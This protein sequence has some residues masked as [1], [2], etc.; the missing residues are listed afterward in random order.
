MAENSQPLSAANNMKM[1]AF[2]QH[3]IRGAQVFFKTPLS[4][5]F[6]NKKPV[7][8]GHVLVSPLRVVERFHDMTSEEVADMFRAVHIIAKAVE[9]EYEGTAMSL[10]LQDGPDAGQT[11][12]HVHIHILPRR[13]GDFS[14]NDE[15]YSHLQDHD[16]V[17]FDAIDA[18]REWRSEEDMAQEATKL[19]KLFPQSYT[20]DL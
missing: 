14:H 5:G 4:Y 12:K 13:K 11:V 10:G 2:G 15:I 9:V 6:V 20:Q 1:Y 7:L 8:P 18:A 17:S 16:H 3:L 19:R